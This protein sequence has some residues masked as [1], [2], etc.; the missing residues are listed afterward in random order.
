MWRLYR[1]V[2]WQFRSRDFVRDPDF[3]TPFLDS[4]SILLVCNDLERNTV[5][6]VQREKMVSGRPKLLNRPF[7]V[8]E[9]LG[10]C[11]RTGRPFVPS[12]HARLLDERAQ[13]S[14]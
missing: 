10:A 6:I 11:R 5:Q 4:A 13:P 1:W 8:R 12:A 3:A 2:D 14:D 9:D 7:A